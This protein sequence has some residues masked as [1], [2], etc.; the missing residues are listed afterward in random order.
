MS[1]AAKLLLAVQR[2]AAEFK[3]VRNRLVII[4][5]ATGDDLTDQSEA[6]LDVSTVDSYGT[7]MRFSNGSGNKGRIDLTDDNGTEWIVGPNPP[8]GAYLQING[9]D[10]AGGIAS[11]GAVGIFT[12]AFQIT[13]PT[14]VSV[15]SFE[16]A[17]ASEAPVFNDDLTRKD[18][19]DGLNAPKNL[20]RVFTDCI[21]A[22][23]SAEFGHTV[24]GTGAAF[25]QGA[26]GSINNT[27]VGMLL[28]A[29]GT[30]ATNRVSISSPNA[31]ILTFIYP[32]RTTEFATRLWMLVLSDATNAYTLR[33]GFIDS[34]TTDSV[35]GVYF[36]YTHSVNG[37]L[38]QCVARNNNT[39]TVVNATSQFNTNVPIKLTVRV[40]NVANVL[41]ADFYVNAALAGTITTNIPNAAARDTGY[42]VYVQRSAGTAAVTPLGVDYIDVKQSWSPA[43][44][45]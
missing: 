6:P 41:T 5:G 33:A 19:V 35:D 15:A 4:R 16:R 29:L 17:T 36:R 3:A 12:Q 39:E 23:N 27:A 45:D 40:K 10:A 7:V 25:T 44:R 9:R 37:G 8:N 43:I 11:L 24:S 32:G 14:L 13:H 18:Y 26:A 30:V 22:V 2:I 42:G 1:L 34:V 38:L 28:F 20:F 31:S 21:A